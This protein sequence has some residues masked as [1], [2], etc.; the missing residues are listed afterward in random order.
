MVAKLTSLLSV[1][2]NLYILGGR[3]ERCDLGSWVRR[4][5]ST[6]PCPGNGG[7]D[8]RTDGERGGEATYEGERWPPRR[9]PGRRVDRRRTRLSR[10]YNLRCPVRVRPSVRPERFY[11]EDPTPQELTKSCPAREEPTLTTTP[12]DAGSLI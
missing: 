12:L 11:R 8:L 6:V 1:W 5:I 2:Y 10:S 9:R 3:H 7:W 4:V